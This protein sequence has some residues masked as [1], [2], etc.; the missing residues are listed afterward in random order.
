MDSSF[1][2]SYASNH[3]ASR[4]ECRFAFQRTVSPKT[5]HS[6]WK[7]SALAWR[8]CRMKT[9]ARCRVSMIGKDGEEHSLETK[10]DCLSEAAHVGTAC[11]FLSQ[12]RCGIEI[13][14]MCD[15]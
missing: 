15:P 4:C 1:R 5:D 2:D 10:S 6:I 11:Q 7:N 12:A 8:E 9:D 3:R 14:L 13:K